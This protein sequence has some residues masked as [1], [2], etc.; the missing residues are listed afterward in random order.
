MHKKTA[1]RIV[2]DWERIDRMEKS[3]TAQVPR[4]LMLEVTNAC[5]LRCRMC[6]NPKM[7]RARGSM[8]LEMGIRAIREA[9]EIGVNEVGLFTTGEPLLYSYLEALIE[10]AKKN[11][12]YCFMTSKWPAF[13]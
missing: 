13:E 6:G 11:D 1:Q 10:E 5:N 2:T 7:T 4:L 8:P 3:E 12:L 9:A